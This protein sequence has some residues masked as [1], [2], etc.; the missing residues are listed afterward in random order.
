MTIGFFTVDRKDHA[1]ELNYLC[2]RALLVSA[3]RVMPTTSVVQFTDVKS[4]AVKG[5]DA[6]RRKPSE[7]MALL[8]MRHHAGVS[9]EWLFVDTDVIF[10]HSVKRVFVDHDFQIGLTTRD[11]SHLK[12]AMGFTDR[13]PFNTGVVFSR[14]AHFW[15][16]VYTRLRLLEPEKQEWMGD[17]EVIGD[18]VS[19][20][21]CPY[22]I[23][24]L[25]GSKYNFPPPVVSLEDERAKALTVEAEASIIHYKGPGR[26]AL[27]LERIKGM[28]KC[29]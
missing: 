16:D 26:K 21:T 15:G 13:M 23:A 1:S 12:P 7:P 9:G 17:Q 18:L 28:K 2:A 22:A 4:R 10:Q 27:L 8:R 11:W 3:K 14:C 19:E 20:D 6:V 5:V 24:H 29:A 25:K